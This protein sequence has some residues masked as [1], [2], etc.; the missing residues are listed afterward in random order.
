MGRAGKCSRFTFWSF[1][2]DRFCV[3]VEHGVVE[4]VVLCGSGGS[5]FDHT[6]RVR[7]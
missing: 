4:E 1:L 5:L 6:A 2:E 3:D 7:M